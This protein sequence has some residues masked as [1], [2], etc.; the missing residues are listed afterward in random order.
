MR[1]YFTFNKKLIIIIHDLPLQ[2][3]KIFTKE[4]YIIKQT[5]FNNGFK[6]DMGKQ[7]T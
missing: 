3:R 1:V 6:T 7:P 4:L 2:V 5:A